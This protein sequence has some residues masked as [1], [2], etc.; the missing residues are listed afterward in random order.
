MKK[1]LS[2][3]LI[4]CFVLGLCAATLAE[5]PAPIPTLDI[6]RHQHQFNRR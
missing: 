3:A 5:P 1:G 2:I 6:P 4:F